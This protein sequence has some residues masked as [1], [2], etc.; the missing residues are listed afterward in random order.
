VCPTGYHRHRAEMRIPRRF[1][2]GLFFRYIKSQ[3]RY[4]KIS[5]KIMEIQTN[6]FKPKYFF[7]T[8]LKVLVYSVGFVFLLFIDFQKQSFDWQYILLTALTGFVAF[9]GAKNI[10]KEIEFNYQGIIVRY[11]AWLE[12]EVE[13][14]DIEDI[15]VNITIK[16]RGLVISL[17]EMTNRMELQRKV[18]DILRER[19]IAKIDID[20]KIRE[21]KRVGT[22][23]LN[24]ALIVTAAIGIVASFIIHADLATWAISLF[25]LFVL[26]LN[27]LT[28]FIK[29]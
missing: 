24:Y 3:D 13:Y 29:T 10:V 22:K 5:N 6:I 17:R 1:V 4:D 2:E 28:I 18:A 21:K 11:Y 12:K 26:I 7:T 14:Q 23:V 27:I 20:Q 25:I 15:E 9:Q 16:A 8:Y 19:K